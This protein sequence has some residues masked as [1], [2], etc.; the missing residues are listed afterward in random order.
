MSWQSVKGSGIATFPPPALIVLK[1]GVEMAS[2][3]LG[4]PTDYIEQ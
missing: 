2:L 3:S 4:S 1:A